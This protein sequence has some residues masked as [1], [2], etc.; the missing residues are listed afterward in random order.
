MENG[1]MS[2]AEQR[3]RTVADF[4]QSGLSRH[5]YCAQHKLSVH[6]LDSWRR[7]AKTPRFVR[8]QPSPQTPSQY[9]VVLTNGRRIETS[10]G[11]DE[12]ELARLIHAVES[13]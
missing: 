4:E 12:H 5:Q 10:S 11:F 8:V 3:E 6:T 7:K 2:K 9:T 1:A 13:R